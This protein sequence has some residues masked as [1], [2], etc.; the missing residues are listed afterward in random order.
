MDKKKFNKI[1]D[2]ALD[3]TKDFWDKEKTVNRL[4]EIVGNDV[5]KVRLEDAMVFARLEAVNYT[6]EFVYN[7]L[8]DLLVNDQQDQ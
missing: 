1:F 7:L 6:N 8:Y 4:K 3:E 2:Q 5:K